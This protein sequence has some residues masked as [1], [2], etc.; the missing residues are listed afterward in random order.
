MT[1]DTTPSHPQLKVEIS[2]SAITPRP[3]IVSALGKVTNLPLTPETPS[4][5]LQSYTAKACS[6][7][8]LALSSAEKGPAHAQ[9]VYDELHVF[10]GASTSGA[11]RQELA[12]SLAHRPGIPI[13]SD[14]SSTD[15]SNFADIAIVDIAE[16]IK[17]G[18]EGQEAG[19]RA[20]DALSVLARVCIVGAGRQE[21]A[22]TLTRQSHLTLTPNTPTPEILEKVRQVCE[23]V[24][25]TVAERRTGQE[26][27]QTVYDSLHVLAGSV[28][29]S[30]KKA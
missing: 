14:T 23:T 8:A 20:H 15:L 1:L 13:N 26:A 12:D 28:I 9:A 6:R 19:Q 27:A 22:D 30:S 29:A 11:G 10:A 17:A 21:L 2:S 4:A 18:S 3:E 24:A 7:V 16:I 25:N 5:Q